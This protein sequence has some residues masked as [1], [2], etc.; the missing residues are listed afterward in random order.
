MN[1]NKERILN[2]R[3]RHSD[4]SLVGLSLGT[5]LGTFELEKILVDLDCDGDLKYEN[6]KI[7][8]LL[9]KEFQETAPLLIAEVDYVLHSFLQ[10]SP[11]SVLGDIA[12]V[13]ELSREKT[14]SLLASH[15][16]RGLIT[17]QK[18]AYRSLVHIPV[19]ELNL[20][21]VVGMRTL[22]T[23]I[24]CAFRQKRENLF[25]FLTALVVLLLLFFFVRSR[26]VTSPSDILEG[27]AT[28]KADGEV[29]DIISLEQRRE[30]LQKD[31]RIQNT[32]QV[33]HCHQIWS[34]APKEACAIHGRIYTSS[35]WEKKQ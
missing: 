23:P 3:K 28:I 17:V 27:F 8:K 34:R 5:G 29:L 13:L 2:L 22:E 9:R 25:A 4:I 31:L 19:E 30:N 26:Q 7:I 15:E 21:Q 35:S 24:E 12:L 16:A 20:C 6:Q 11:Q 18:G 1:T 32:E 33:D 14:Q 10:S